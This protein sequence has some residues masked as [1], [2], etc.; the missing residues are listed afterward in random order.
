MHSAS[1]PSESLWALVF[2]I[3]VEDASRS[4]M[5]PCMVWGWVR[6]S[7]QSL[8]VSPEALSV[9]PLLASHPI[10]P[11]LVC[12]VAGV[13][14][15]AE[16]GPRNARVIAAREL[17]DPEHRLATLRSALAR[18]MVILFV[19]VET[20]PERLGLVDVLGEIA[21]RVDEGAQGSARAVYAVNVTRLL[22]LCL[23]CAHRDDL[24]EALRDMPTNRMGREALALIPDSVPVRRAGWFERLLQHPS[25]PVYL[26]VFAYSSLRV[27]PVTLVREFHGS[28]LVLWMIDVVTAIPYTWGVL[29]MIFSAKRRIRLLAALTTLVTFVV[30]YVY[31]WLHGTAYP[32]YVPIVIAALTIGSV[33][34]EV[35]RFVQ[36]Q[37]LRRRYRSVS[38]VPSSAG[39]PVSVIAVAR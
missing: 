27:L 34:L 22:R 33:L 13:Q 30:P 11:E 18:G 23:E 37:R 38:T 14:R 25:L 24:D 28:L 4:Y 17:T 36:E 21:I 35:N 20:D 19:A 15:L 29:A 5:L 1:S 9:V 16:I 26:I 3:L 31:F 10:S 8:L 6:R 39:A 2:R 12:Q 32:P 7:A